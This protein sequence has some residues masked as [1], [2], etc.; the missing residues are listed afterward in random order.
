MVILARMKRLLLLAGCLVGFAAC[1]DDPVDAEGDYTINVTNRDN[2]CSF[3]N[4]T[5]GNSA[6]DIKVTINQ[7]GETAGADVM[8]ITG[9]YLDLI[10][11]SHVFNGSIDGDE[12]DLKIP[13]TRS[14]V[15]GNCT[16]TV[17]ATLIA[18]LNGDILTGRI[19][20]SKNGN[21][22]TD[23]A[24]ID[25]CLSVQEMNGARAPQ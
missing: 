14:A 13:G 5:A 22:N 10:L 25:G 1:S 8:G 21:D 12:L 6:M 17:D 18:T 24:P 16:W 2:G 4:W 7:E 3:D 20:Y 9:A 19:N 11:G 15:T 23:C